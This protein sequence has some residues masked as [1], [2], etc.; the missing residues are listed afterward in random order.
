MKLTQGTMGKHSALMVGL[1]PSPFIG[2][3]IQEPNG[4]LGLA[5]TSK[6]LFLT[7]VVSVLES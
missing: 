1:V 6:L 7:G 2:H 4:G 5:D 3:H